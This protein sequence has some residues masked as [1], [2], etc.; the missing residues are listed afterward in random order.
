MSKSTRIRIFA[1]LLCLLM[2]GNIFSLVIPVSAASEISIQNGTGNREPIRVGDSFSYRAI[3]N[4]AFTGFAFSMPTWE[5]KTSSCTVSLYKWNTNFDTTVSQ[6]PLAQKSFNPMV[7]GNYH[8][9]EFDEQPA[10]EY[11]FHVSDASADVGV[12]TNTGPSNPKGF[13]YINGIEQR[14]EPQMV[15]RF[16]DTQDTPFGD[17]QASADINNPQMPYSLR[18]F[19]PR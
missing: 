16:T 19:R 10:G 7:D 11:L 17:C 6:S 3:V 1:I 4:G 13:M 18:D 14:G 12:W 15:I 8:W 2:I 5:K 9:V